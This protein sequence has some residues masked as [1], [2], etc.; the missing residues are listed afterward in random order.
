MPRLIWIH[1]LGTG[2]FE[3]TYCLTEP[4]VERL[5]D[6]FPEARAALRTPTGLPVVA[7]ARSATGGLLQLV[8]PPGPGWSVERRCIETKAL[9]TRPEEGKEKK[10]PL[11]YLDDD[12][13][14]WCAPC[15]TAATATPGPLATETGPELL[16]GT[17]RTML[18]E[19]RELRSGDAIFVEATS[20]LRP[21]LMALT[22]GVGLVRE[23]YAGVRVLGTSYAEWN[24]WELTASPDAYPRAKPTTELA[25]DRAGKH[26]LSPVHDLTEL[27]ALPDWAAAGGDLIQRLDTGRL[28]RQL[29]ADSDLHPVLA[30]SLDLAWPEDSIA[31]LRQ[32]GSELHAAPDPSLPPARATVREVLSER[33]GPL[34]EGS[35]GLSEDSLHIDRVDYYLTYAHSLASARR[36][37]DA[38]R[39]L[40]ETMVTRMAVGLGSDAA[41]TVDKRRRLA[42]YE[43]FRSKVHGALWKDL[44]HLRNKSSHANL[45]DAEGRIDA[46]AV[47]DAFAGAPGASILG[48]VATA[49]QAEDGWTPAERPS[50]SVLW[51]VAKGAT[52]PDEP[53]RG[54]VGAWLDCF[55][56][57]IQGTQNRPLAGVPRKAPAAACPGSVH[58]DLTLCPAPMV[59]GTS[60]AAK[61]LKVV[62]KARPRDVV[63]V[64]VDDPTALVALGAALLGMGCLGWSWSP[65]GELADQKAP[66]PLR[67]LF[68]RA[69]HDRLRPNA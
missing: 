10:S 16:A 29:T 46:S 2:N 18:A 22:L 43:L 6:V 5:E 9:R 63:L 58:S 25:K 55:A 69:D 35:C 7:T 52:V 23:L 66:V 42:E 62:Q 4:L 47:L 61:R 56:D 37:G 27:L 8:G 44:G 45:G 17:V 11:D 19:V 15:A 49:C 39:V 59:P 60:W 36:Y 13:P 41:P 67:P 48:R 34:L 14:P 12:L 26:R 1:S 32:V 57:D 33:L 24:A 50:S 53:D 30:D 38:L 31:P 20:G 28:Q 68:T 3:A 51:L 65:A 54:K 40:R 21:I 64:G